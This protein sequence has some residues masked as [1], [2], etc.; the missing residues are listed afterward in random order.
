V[1]D[2]PN[3]LR[4]AH[5]LSYAVGLALCFGTPSLIAV[6][7][8]AGVVAPGQEVPEGIYLQVGYLFTGVVFLSAAWVW[9]R[10]GRMLRGFKALPE[11]QRASVVIR[12][13][14]IYSTIFEASSF[15]G[16]AYWMLVGAHAARHAWGFIL[17][18][19]A[20]FLTLV[21]RYRHWAERLES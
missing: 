8:L 18:T 14:L 1:N 3:P 6:L 16:L 12:E 7:L 2:R 20:L 9:G 19:P 17:L 10:R 5:R 21:P 15:C 11:G 4:A 13:G